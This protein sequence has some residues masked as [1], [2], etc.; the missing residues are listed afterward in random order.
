MENVIIMW[1]FSITYL[2]FIFSNDRLLLVDSVVCK[3]LF[4]FSHWWE[5]SVSRGSPLCPP[6]LQVLKSE[7]VLRK[8]PARTSG[9]AR[10]EFRLVGSQAGLSVCW[11][12]HQEN[13]T[14]DAPPGG[15]WNIRGKP[16]RSTW[17]SQ[18]LTGLPAPAQRDA[19]LVPWKPALEGSECLLIA[20][21]Q[22]SHHCRSL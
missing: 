21:L 5:R 17:P 4:W 19:F 6:C 13:G 15:L 12:P 18:G 3:E 16:Q 1:F 11:F 7:V 9:S 20:E 8:C 14:G 22:P 2:W 10:S